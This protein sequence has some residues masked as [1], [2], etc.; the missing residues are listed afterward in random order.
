MSTTPRR[1][2]QLVGAQR[3]RPERPPPRSRASP[4]A[5]SYEVVSSDLFLA[6]SRWQDTLEISGVGAHISAS[7]KTKFGCDLKRSCTNQH[8][9]R[10]RRLHAALEAYAHTQ[11]GCARLVR[12]DATRGGRRRSTSC[13]S[14]GHCSAH[15]PRSRARTNQPSMCDVCV[16][17]LGTW[18]V[19]PSPQPRARA[20]RARRRFRWVGTV[21]RRGLHRPELVWPQRRPHHLLR[22]D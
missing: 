8:E 14:A 20:R 18:W 1:L 6:H 10:R 21:D 15:C 12:L 13:A 4:P 3:R 16:G 5:R 7:W 11:P 9:R 2:Q 19:H 17:G 22:S